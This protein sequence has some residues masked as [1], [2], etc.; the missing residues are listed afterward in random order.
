MKHFL[1]FYNEE[2]TYYYPDN[3][4]ATPELDFP[5]VNSGL[6]LV[7]ETDEEG[8]YFYT[9]PVTLK[10]LANRHDVNINGLS[11]EEALQAIEDKLNK[12]LPAPEPTAESRIAA[13]LEYQNLLNL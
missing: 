11:D 7:I 12:P 10:V 1:E 4:L 5:I 13:A 3:K 8:I 9:A 6:K 2:K